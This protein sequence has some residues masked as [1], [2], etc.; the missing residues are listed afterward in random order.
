MMDRPVAV[1]DTE[2]VG[3]RDRRADPGLGA[4]HR[5]LEGL[6]LGETGSDGRGQRAAGAMG[7][8]G[9]DARR[10]KCDRFLCIDEIVAALGALAVPALDQHRAT[11]EREQATPLALDLG[12]ASRKRLVE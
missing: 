4:A 10:G 3:S 11:T 9:G 1:A 7:I 8:F 2:T 12:F 5:V 6:A